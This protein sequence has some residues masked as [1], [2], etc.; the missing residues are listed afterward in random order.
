MSDTK[1]SK[2]EG[3]NGFLVS[4]IHKIDYKEDLNRCFANLCTDKK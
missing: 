4:N 2:R 3:Q 1:K